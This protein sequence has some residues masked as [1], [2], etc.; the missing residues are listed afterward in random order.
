LN[1]RGLHPARGLAA[2]AFA[3]TGL[4]A[5]TPDSPTPARRATHADSVFI[6]RTYFSQGGDEYERAEL[7]SA[8]AHYELGL[9]WDPKNAMAWQTKAATLGRM[10]RYSESLAAFDVTLRLKPDYAFA[11][12]HRGCLNAS[13]GHFEEA[14]SDLRHMIAIDSTMK[15]W[16]FHD[17]C[18]DSLL[19]DPRLLELTR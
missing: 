17:E 8:L 9:V 19:A 4:G 10:G 6:A 11:W 18:W 13:S 12:W 15:S 5:A 1:R 14:L 16:P 3:L 2:L 7:D